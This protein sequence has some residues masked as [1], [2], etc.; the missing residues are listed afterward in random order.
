MQALRS[1]TIN[2]ARYLG[3]DKDVGSLEVGK[4]ADLMIVDGDVLHDIRQ[5]DRVT[6][7]MLNGRLYD[8]ATMNEVGATKKTRKPFFFEGKSGVNA[9]VGA[10]EYSHGGD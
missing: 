8:S 10:A 9:P 5:S 4:L 1:A 6:Q 2:G 3:L 7:V